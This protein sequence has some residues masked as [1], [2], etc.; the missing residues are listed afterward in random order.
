[1]LSQDIWSTMAGLFPDVS[2]GKTSIKQAF[3]FEYKLCTGFPCMGAIP[4]AVM[5]DR[6][7]SAKECYVDHCDHFG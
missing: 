2:M 1:M 3:I 7:D 4:M 6:L 5:E